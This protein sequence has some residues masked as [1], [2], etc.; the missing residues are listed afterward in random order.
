M[1]KILL[2]LYGLCFSCFADFIFEYNHDHEHL[3]ARAQYKNAECSL[4]AHTLSIM[5]CVAIVFVSFDFSEEVTKTLFRAIRT[6]KFPIFFLSNPSNKWMTS[7]FSFFSRI[8]KTG[9]KKQIQFKCQLR[10]WS[11]INSLKTAHSELSSALCLL[12][13]MF[14]AI[15]FNI[16]NSRCISFGF[17]TY[18]SPV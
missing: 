8:V 17:V 14:I 18:K 9:W 15:K 7:V 4:L 10:A 13:S 16:I 2:I 3:Y 1:A 11:S 6:I 12:C 5:I